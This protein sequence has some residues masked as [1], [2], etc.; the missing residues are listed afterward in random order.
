[1]KYKLCVLRHKTFIR[2]PQKLLKNAVS[3]SVRCMTVEKIKISVPSMTAS[4]ILWIP[5]PVS[6]NEKELKTSDHFQLNSIW[7]YS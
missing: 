1:M 2:F 7:T 3:A 6:Y 5:I 4:E